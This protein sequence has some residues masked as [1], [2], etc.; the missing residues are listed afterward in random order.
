MAVNREVKDLIA[1]CVTW[2][3]WRVEEV[4]KGWMIYPPDKRLP[5]IAVHKTPSDHR[6]WKNTLSRLRRSGAPL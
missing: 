1:D 2:P 4:K 5:A 3:G 6:A